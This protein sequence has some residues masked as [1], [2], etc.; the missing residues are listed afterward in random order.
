MV[1]EWL[2]REATI[3]FIYATTRKEDPDTG[4]NSDKAVVG[5]EAFA[6]ARAASRAILVATI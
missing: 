4:R 2:P 6:G 5:E 1:D 3:D